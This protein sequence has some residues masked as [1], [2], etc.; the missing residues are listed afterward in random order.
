[1]FVRGHGTNVETE[2]EFSWN[3]RGYGGDCVH[4]FLA[5]VVSHLASSTVLE[6]AGHDYLRNLEI[7]DSVYRSH[8]CRRYV[9]IG[10]SD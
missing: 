5:H 6:T 2:I 1:L 9:I 10:E 4:R 8:Q 7:E 3:D